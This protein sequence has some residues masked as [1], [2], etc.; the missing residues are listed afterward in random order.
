[1]DHLRPLRLVSLVSDSNTTL[2]PHHQS[3]H[4]TA[5]T[6]TTTT[7]AADALVQGLHATIVRLFR[8]FCGGEEA[9]APVA[10]SGGVPEAYSGQNYDDM[11]L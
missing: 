5:T 2:R 3:P 9:N 1:M 7:T 11:I 8:F 6:S 10:L 4:F